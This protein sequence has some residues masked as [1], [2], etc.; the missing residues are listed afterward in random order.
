[1][2]IIGLI[3]KNSTK[4]LLLII[5]IIIIVG[6]PYSV[7]LASEV[8]GESISNLADGT[9]KLVTIPFALVIYL[10]GYKYLVERNDIGFVETACWFGLLSGVLVSYTVSNYAMEYLIHS[11]ISPTSSNPSDYLYFSIVS[12]T[13]LG[14]GDF[15][16]KQEFRLLAASEALVG[17][18]YL[19]IIVGLT[20]SLATS[21]RNVSAEGEES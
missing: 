15:A 9:S 6:F 18:L 21:S 14:Y 16:P 3:R 19:G 4:A 1:M 12:F 13:T 20:I 5:L 7:Y 17:Y 8:L 11:A 10:M 2:K